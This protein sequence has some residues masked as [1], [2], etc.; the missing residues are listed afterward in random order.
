M[1]LIARRRCRP[2]SQSFRTP[3]RTLL[4]HRARAFDSM[5]AAHWGPFT[6][7]GAGRDAKQ[8]YAELTAESRRCAL[9][10]CCPHA[11]THC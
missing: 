9:A 8:F 5:V 6:I 7:W 10:L 11:L 1:Q 2:G 4:H 3:R